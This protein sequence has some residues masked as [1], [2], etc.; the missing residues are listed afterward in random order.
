MNGG[1]VSVEL[2]CWYTALLNA[3]MLYKFKPNRSTRTGE[4]FYIYYVMQNA[5]WVSLSAIKITAFFEP[6]NPLRPNSDGSQTSHCN[7][8]ELSVSQVMRIENVI[9]QV[10]F[11]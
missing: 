5:Q 4:K 11:Y 2:S 9:T 10:K 8:K 1:L 7:V 6:F 3:P